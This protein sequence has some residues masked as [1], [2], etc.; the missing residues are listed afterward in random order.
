[1]RKVS[2]ELV[3]YS[4]LHLFSGFL[5]PANNLNLQKRQVKALL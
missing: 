4:Y 2:C 3:T 1:M 5:K